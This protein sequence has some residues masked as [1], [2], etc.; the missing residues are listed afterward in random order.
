[1]PQAFEVLQYVLVHWCFRGLGVGSISFHAW[2]HVSY[3]FR[4]EHLCSMLG[5]VIQLLPNAEDRLWLDGLNFCV[6]CG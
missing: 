3:Q 4:S 6:E 1:M 5:E 2:P